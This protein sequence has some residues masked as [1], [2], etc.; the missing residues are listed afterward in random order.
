MPFDSSTR[1]R[2]SSMKRSTP[3]SCRRR[4][5]RQ[6]SRSPSAPPRR[7]PSSRYAAV[8]TRSE[9]RSTAIDDAGSCEPWASQP[10]R[11]TAAVAACSS[12]GVWMNPFDSRVPNVVGHQL[13]DPAEATDPQ[14]APAAPALGVER[15]RG[16]PGDP[17][18]EPVAREAERLAQPQLELLAE[19]GR[20]AS[21]A[22]SH[23]RRAG[24]RGRR[25]SRSR[26]A[27]AAAASPPSGSGPVGHRPGNSMSGSPPSPA[28]RFSRRGRRGS[29]RRAAAHPRAQRGQVVVRARAPV[30]ATSPRV[31]SSSTS[32]SS[33]SEK[34]I[35]GSAVTSSLRTPLVASGY[36]SLE[37]DLAGHVGVA[38]PDHRVE[39]D[40]ARCRRRRP[41]GPALR[42]RPRQSSSQGDLLLDG[43]RV[44][45]R[46]E[47]AAARA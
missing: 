41:R 32:G 28:W 11:S 3:A 8:R 23:R 12:E 45:D 14:R 44:V 22:R 21:P 10:A 4:S 26:S 31:K 24:S 16:Q 40:H 47:E 36:H 20:R 37:R 33:S 25:R 13:L 6:P 5:N 27:A 46:A 17:G 42:A 43:E 18:V 29:G 9:R 38:E 2:Q 30:V 1:R 39:E 7:T 34:K 15:S 19:S 35:F